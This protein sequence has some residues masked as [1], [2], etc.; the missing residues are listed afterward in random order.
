MDELAVPASTKDYWL[1]S[2]VLVTEI[3]GLV[4]MPAIT[5]NRC[6]LLPHAPSL[7]GLL[8]RLDRAIVLLNDDAAEQATKPNPALAFPIALVVPIHILAGCKRSAL[9][10]ASMGLVRGAFCEFGPAQAWLREM[11]ALQALLGR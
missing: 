1:E 9:K 3:R 6:R 7:A 11:V 5:F 2:G 10:A 8:Y 4:S